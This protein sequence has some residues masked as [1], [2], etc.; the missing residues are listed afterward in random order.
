MARFAAILADLGRDGLE[1]RHRAAHQHD[2]RAEGGEFMG[3]QR[4]M[5]LPAPVTMMVWPANRP[6][7]NT[8][9]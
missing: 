2:V 9:R 7:R 1:L 8:L 3:V 4:P 6:G 5:P